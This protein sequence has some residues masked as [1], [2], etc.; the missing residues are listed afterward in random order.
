M[1]L[2]NFQFYFDLAFSDS[3]K[4]LL[5]DFIGNQQLLSSGFE[6]LEEYDYYLKDEMV[7]DDI[8]PV[9]VM[10][11]I[12]R[13]KFLDD[14]LNSHKKILIDELRIATNLLAPENRGVFL[15][16]FFT[17]FYNVNKKILSLDFEHQDK[18]VDN[19]TQIREDLK[20]LYKDYL[21]NHRLF[22]KMESLGN[23]DFG[24]FFGLK[25]SLKKSFLTDLYDLC[26]DLFIIDDEKVSESDFID[27]F[28]SSKPNPYLKIIFEEKNYPIVYFLESIQ[29]FFDN[30][31]FTSIEQSQNFYNKQNK[32]LTASDLSATKSRNKNSSP[33]IIKKIDTAINTL[34]SQNLR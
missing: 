18:V 15:N 4:D 6:Y 23:I 21:S 10:T 27:V 2:S 3:G 13:D 7:V 8:Q 34:K 25:P 26:I 33:P 1:I 32:L 30:L 20:L 12:N 9:F 28:T 11:I 24:T 29:P 14:K 5:S 22:G 17:E 19:L 31:T 16:D